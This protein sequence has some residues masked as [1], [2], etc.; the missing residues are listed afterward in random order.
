MKLGQ[1]F[2]LIGVLAPI[3]WA[4]TSGFSYGDGYSVIQI[5]KTNGGGG[6]KD[7][8]SI[9][10]FIEGHTLTMNFSQAIGS[11]DVEISNAMGTVQNFAVATPDNVQTYI[12]NSGSYTV[13]FTLPGG[14][15]YY[16]N[17]VVF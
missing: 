4:A 15:E 13:T 10:A 1:V 7:D 6:V 16:G 5:K 2:L 9:S 3:I 11:V 12:T 8:F 17:F 14:D